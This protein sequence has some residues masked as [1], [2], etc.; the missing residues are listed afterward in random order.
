MVHTH[1]HT[2]THTH[3][4]STAQ[5]SMVY[6]RQPYTVGDIIL[7]YDIKLLSKANDNLAPGQMLALCA[8]AAISHVIN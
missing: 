6:P 3:A 8:E 5:H 7:L 4:H 1:T 2:H